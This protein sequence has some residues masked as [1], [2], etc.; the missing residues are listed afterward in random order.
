MD[1]KQLERIVKKAAAEAFKTE[2]GTLYVEREQHY[3]DH[4][5]IQGFR[6]WSADV[7]STFWK[8]IIT[9]I[10]WTFLGLLLLGFVVWVRQQIK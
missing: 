1:P 3:L 4:Q 6:K 10:G 5:F 2:L 8:T 9:G 7:K